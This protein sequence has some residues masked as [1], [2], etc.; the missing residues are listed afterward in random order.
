M[1][2]NIDTLICSGGSVRC[3][4]FI[5]SFRRIEELIAKGLEES[6][7][8][9]PK[10]DIK[11]VAGVSAGAMFSL[12]YTVGYTSEEMETEMLNTK[13]ERL[14]EIKFMNF[15]SKYGLDTGKLVIN[16]LE[17]LLAKKSIPKT[18]T[19]SE[20]YQRTQIDLQ[21]FAA[22]VNR[23]NL[24]KFNWECTPDIKVLDAVRMSMSIPFLFTTTH[25]N[26]TTKK[27]NCKEGDIHVDAGLI[28]NYPIAQFKDRLDTVL[29]LKVISQ[30][31]LDSHTVDERIDDI[32]SYIYHVLACF[33]IQREKKTSSNELFREHT[34]YIHTENITQTLNFELSNEEK[35]RLIQIGYAATEQFFN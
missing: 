16:W 14:K 20:L 6:E 8:H 26:I 31:E 11:T 17:G 29:G 35:L 24:T 19:F 22:N 18:I 15:L 4:S 5:G 32:E 28:D 23:Y 1:K 12:M 13:L 27:I 9:F 10:I 7:Q 3:I 34:V 2:R 21:I 25:F 33:I 30:G